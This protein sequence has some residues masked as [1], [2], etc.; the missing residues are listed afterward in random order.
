MCKD[1][2][3]EAKEEYFQRCEY[4]KTKQQLKESEND[5]LSAENDMELD[6][7]TIHF[8]AI[9]ESYVTG[10]VNLEEAANIMYSDF[11]ITLE[12]AKQLLRS[13]QRDNVINIVDYLGN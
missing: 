1:L 2:T 12:E 7:D 9:G 6:H 5:F 8:L 4:E 3:Y 11:D 13:L 10:K